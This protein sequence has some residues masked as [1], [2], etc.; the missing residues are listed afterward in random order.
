MEMT[1][2]EYVKNLIRFVG[3]EGY[4]DLFPVF[5][6][7][8]A[9]RYCIWALAEWVGELQERGVYF[10]KIVSMEAKGF[11]VGSM[12]AQRLDLPFAP[13]AKSGRFHKDQDP[14]REITVDYSGREKEFEITR[15]HIK[16]GERILLVDDWFETGAQ[17]RTAMKLIE[18]CGATVV[19]LCGI[20]D[21]TKRSKFAEKISTDYPFYCV[22]A[23]ER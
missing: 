8:E 3:E 23:L 20:V 4:G 18:R 15:D 16:E 17:A 11:V 19:A 12:L 5:A 7:A 9:R 14:L 2:S 10:D 13:I 22:I 1:S 6:D 21:D